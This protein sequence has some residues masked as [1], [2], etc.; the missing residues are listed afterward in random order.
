MIYLVVFSGKMILFFPKMWSYSLDGKW[1]MIFLQKIHGNMIFPLNAPKRRSSKKIIL[2][3]DRSYIIWKD[4]I[5]FPENMILFLWT[6]NERWPFQEIR[7]HMIFSVYMYEC[8][9]HDITLPQKKK[10]K[11]KISDDPLPKKNTLKG[12]WH[13]RS[14]SS[15]KLP[16]ISKYSNE[17]SKSAW[18]SFEYPTS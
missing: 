17:I 9:K 7:G 1:K 10:K 12:N 6:E 8:Y 15:N 3:Y 18:S 14:H 16:T 4:G 11:K 13:S 5:F 2:E